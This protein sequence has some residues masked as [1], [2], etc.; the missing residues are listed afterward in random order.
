MA[1]LISPKRTKNVNEL[2][3]AVMQWEQTL[4]E[5]ESKFS[6]AV[7]DSVETAAM[8]REILRC[9]RN[10]VSAYVGEKLV[11]QDA[12]GGAQPLSSGRLTKPKGR[13]QPR[14]SFYRSNQKYE[15]ESDNER[16]PFNC[17]LFHHQHHASRL[18]ETRNRGMMKRNRVQA[19]KSVSFAASAVERAF[20]PGSA[21]QQMIAKMRMKSK[22]SRPVTLTVIC[23]VWVGATTQPRPSTQ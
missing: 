7:A 12:G 13:V 4:G 6:E 15:Q 17:Q 16:K 2:Q 18:H 20:L 1:R 8:R 3:V 10:R 14:G 19:R 22:W 23:L 5:H 21:H 11:G 9:L